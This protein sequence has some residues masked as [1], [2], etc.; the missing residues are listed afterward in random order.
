[1]S[2]DIYAP[3]VELVVDYINQYGPQNVASDSPSVQKKF[4][5]NVGE[6]SLQ[7]TYD[8]K[9]LREYALAIDG[10]DIAHA[11]S[12][13]RAG[14][15]AARIVPTKPRPGRTVLTAERIEDRLRVALAYA[16]G[17]D[18]VSFVFPSGTAAPSAQPDAASA[19]ANA[20]A[21]VD[22]IN[23]DTYCA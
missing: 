13:F 21:R 20:T 10:F 8:T 2:A 17:K 23:P 3:L 19:R 4:G 6:K 15:A 7:H 22:A 18:P 12:T 5:H 11:E 14:I 1:M 9:R 16:S